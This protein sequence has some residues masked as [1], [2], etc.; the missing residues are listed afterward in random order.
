MKLLLF[1]L[2]FLFGFSVV[3]QEVKIGNVT[4]QI[5]LGDL[6]GNRDLAFGVQNVL[7]EVVQDAGYDLNPNS[8]L[9]IT[10][11]L[12]FFDVKKNNVQLAVYSKNTDI[13]TIIARATLYKDG[14]KKKI[15][16]AKGQA[17]SISIATLVVDKGGEFSQANVST[18]IKKLCE[19]LIRKLKL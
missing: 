16:T 11:D 5:I 15:A 2:S 3:A 13:Y 19:D 6:A 4:N 12:L 10:V 14:K 1:L 17:K 8:S 9:E 18:A 7:E